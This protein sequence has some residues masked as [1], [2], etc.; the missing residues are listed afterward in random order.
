GK[1]HGA[2]NGFDMTLGHVCFETFEVTDANPVTHGR[3]LLFVT[4]AAG[5][6]GSLAIQLEPAV[7]PIVFEHKP[8][9]PVKDPGFAAAAPGIYAVAGVTFTVSLRD[10]VLYALVPGQPEYELV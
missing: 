5:R 6:I 7:V 8:D 10:G 2:F 4:D 3:Q 9:S 1:L